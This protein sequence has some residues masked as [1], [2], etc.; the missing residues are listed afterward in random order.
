MQSASTC[1]TGMPFMVVVIVR[2]STRSATQQSR[3]LNLPS[4]IFAG[5]E[6]FGNKFEQSAALPSVSFPQTISAACGW[7]GI[8]IHRGIRRIYGRR[9]G[10][11]KLLEFFGE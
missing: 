7:R 10:W 2:F 5:L 8:E 1:K 9:T 4:R 6:A 11:K 3:G